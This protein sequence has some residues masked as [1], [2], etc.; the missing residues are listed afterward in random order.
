MRAELGQP[1]TNLERLAYQLLMDS[2]YIV[3]KTGDA[4]Q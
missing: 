2:A 3:P 1:P 4:Q